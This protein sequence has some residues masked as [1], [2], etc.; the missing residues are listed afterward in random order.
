MQV[1]EQVGGTFLLQDVKPVALHGALTVITS[2]PDQGWLLVTLSP[3]TSSCSCTAK[4]DSVAVEMHLDVAIRFAATLLL[5]ASVPVAELH[6][7]RSKDFGDFEIVGAA[8]SRV[9]RWASNPGSLGVKFTVENGGV[10]LRL[11]SSLATALAFRILRC[12]G[13]L[14]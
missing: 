7:D 2:G 9:M 1:D 4:E 12:A 11:R 5:L 8:G 14:S 6:E 10:D 13:R 3:C